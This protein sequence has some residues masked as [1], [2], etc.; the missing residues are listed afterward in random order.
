MTIKGTFHLSYLTK[1]I[2]VILC[3]FILS[4]CFTS[5][6][7]Q[8]Q[9]VLTASIQQS[10]NTLNHLKS[11][12]E[13]KQLKNC[14][15]MQDYAEQLKNLKPQFTQLI[16]NLLLDASTDGP[17]YKDLQ[18]RLSTVKNTKPIDL[19]NLEKLI[20]ETQLI[21][22]AANTMSFNDA[23]SDSVNV[24]ADLSENQL[25]R[26]QSVSLQQEKTMNRSGEQ[27]KAGQ[28]IGNPHYGQW[29][30]S[31]NGMSFW[32]WYGA[33][34]LFSTIFDSRRYYYRDWASN[35]S[36]S[37]YHDYGRNRYTSPTEFKKQ[38][39]LQQRT[40]KSF[41]QQGKRFNSPYARQ[42][43]GASSLSRSSQSRPSSGHFRKQSSYR[44]KSTS[45]NRRSSSRTHRSSR[46]GK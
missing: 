25:P 17:L 41:Q 19:A 32:E 43:K 46:R 36:Y 5:R 12:L 7:Q 16:D 30:Q 11:A 39:N 22:E 14:I 9:K 8:A 4:A 29:R 26:I 42:R 34:A 45:S 1:L 6:M 27:A 3:C 31:S 33:Y 37:Y 40:K 35:R 20:Q 38:N 10:E 13:K 15:L 23:L 28:L 24:L 2:S 18:H 44:N 21:T